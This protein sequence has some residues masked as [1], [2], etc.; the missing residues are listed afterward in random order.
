MDFNVCYEPVFLELRADFAQARFSF[1][2]LAARLAPG[3][4]FV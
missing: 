2:N 1:E 4:F 3:A